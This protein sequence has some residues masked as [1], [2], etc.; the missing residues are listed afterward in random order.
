V[1][2]L[3]V[4]GTR[5]GGT[6]AVAHKIGE[7]I[8]AAGYEVD[9]V[10]AKKKPPRVDEYD[11]IVVGSGIRADCWTKE[12]MKF[13]ER[14]AQPLRQKK[15]ALFVCCQMADGKAEAQEKAKGN[16]LL[17]VAAKY[18]LKPISYGFFGAYMDFKK[19]HGLVVDIIVRVNRKRLRARGLD[20]RKIYDTRNW[21]SIT[22]WARDIANNASQ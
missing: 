10:D 3:V 17:R 1:K 19:S 21:D 4:Y 15:T 2:A 12:A 13:I 22:A 5:W 9:V 18:D 7:T 20:T 11:L 8:E 16:Y 6:T 14:N